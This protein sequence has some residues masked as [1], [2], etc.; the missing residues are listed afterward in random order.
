[1]TMT[2]EQARR[3]V[4]END[5]MFRSGVKIRFH[6]LTADWHKT[7]HAESAYDAAFISAVADE[8]NGKPLP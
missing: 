2:I 6:A 4:V 5:S 1:M 7:Q 3:L 8:A